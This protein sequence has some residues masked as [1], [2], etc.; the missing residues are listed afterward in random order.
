MDKYLVKIVA[1]DENF[2]YCSDGTKIPP[3]NGG[4]WDIDIIEKIME[5]EELHEKRRIY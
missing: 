1:C 2:I 5:V 3:P 4:K